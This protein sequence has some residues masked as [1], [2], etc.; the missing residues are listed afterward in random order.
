LSRPK[1]KGKKASVCKSCRNAIDVEY[2]RSVS[3]ARGAE[4]QIVSIFRKVRASSSQYLGRAPKIVRELSM[5]IEEASLVFAGTSLIFGSSSLVNGK[6]S[7][8]IGELTKIRG[9]VP[10]T[11][12]GPAK[13]RGELPK[14]REEASQYHGNDSRYCEMRTPATPAGKERVGPAKIFCGCKTPRKWVLRRVG[15]AF[16]FSVV[17]PLAL[18][19]LG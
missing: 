12:G 3:A 14:I 18:E 8:I 17:F 1:R 4:E 6:P 13:I 15:R 11:L 2:R 7:L 10:L 9:E 16:L 19:A 5:I